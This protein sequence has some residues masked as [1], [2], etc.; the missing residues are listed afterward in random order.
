MKPE[1]IRKLEAYL[2]KLFK[3][4]DIS[5]RALPRKKDS[6]EVYVGDEFVGLISKDTDEGETSYHVTMTILDIDLDQQHE[7]N[8]HIPHSITTIGDA[9]PGFGIVAAVLI[10]TGDLSTLA[11]TT[12]FAV[13][14]RVHDRE[15]RGPGAPPRARGASA[16]PRPVGVPDRGSDR[17]G[18]FGGRS[19]VRAPAAHDGG[20]VRHSGDS[21]HGAGPVCKD[22]RLLSDDEADDSCRGADGGK[23]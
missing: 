7:A 21:G 14:F 16:L 4:S 1:E 13:A 6:V 5:V 2:K 10:S 22:R 9:M 8:M 3:G 23:A 19:A 12:V 20:D 15:H 11:D 17:V 18:R